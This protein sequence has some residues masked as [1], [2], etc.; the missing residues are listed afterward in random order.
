MIPFLDLGA[1]TAALQ[2]EIDDAVARVVR[3]GWYI[4]GPEVATFE[5]QWAAYCGARHCV[6][7]GN[8]L[9]ALHLVLRAMNVGA[10]D[11]VIVAAN[12]FIA[13][14][15]AVSMTGA[16]P[17]LVEPEQATH[18]LNPAKIEEAITPATR[19]IMPT[20]LYGQPA[21]L[22]PILA[23]ARQYGLRVVEDGAQAHGARYK[24]GRIGAHGDAVTWSFYP[25]KNLG[26]L[27]DGGAVTTN[28]PALAE[29]IRVL[30]NYGSARRY[31]NV[32][33]GVNSRLDPIQ[34]AVLG[35]KLSRL[36][37]WNARRVQ[38]ARRYLDA[39]ERSSLI[40]PSVPEWAEPVWHLFVVRSEA[41]DV[42][43]NRLAEI[44]VQ[45]S[46]HYPVPPH[47]QQAYAS[48]GH[49][50]GA[51]PLSEQLAGEVLSLPIGPQL[52][53]EQVDVVIAAVREFA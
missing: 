51:F 2:G 49:A 1:A 17:V 35:V 14:L 28:D 20:H 32:E 5:D 9:D 47:L 46:I 31:V 23:I 50:A 26:A 43:Q 45:T 25:S 39:F 42:L 38:I 8:G 29:R 44:G 21:D 36:D 27:G 53:D 52:T 48:L 41:R 16:T 33:R 15:L 11:E 37:E 7:V 10:G 4:G 13:T 22:N 30:G 6:G 19:V 18:N 34:A 12:G 3:S 40:L 24:H